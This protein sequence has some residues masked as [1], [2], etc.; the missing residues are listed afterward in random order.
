VHLNYLDDYIRRQN[1]VT[2]VMDEKKN[3]RS[4]RMVLVLGAAVAG[5]ALVGFGGL[6]AWQAYT[7]NAGNNF[8]VGTLSHTN[9]VGLGTVCASTISASAPGACSVIVSGAA[10]TS[11]FAG[12]SGTVT[13]TNTGSL[14]STFAMSMPAAPTGG[15]LCADLA[16][17]VTDGEG[18]PATV[19]SQTDLTQTIGPTA[20]DNSNGVATWAHGDHDTFTFAI[21]PY[22]NFANDD[23]VLGSTC[24]FTILFTQASA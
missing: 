8:A 22:N 19:Y 17:T 3:R 4:L 12:T 16:L 18:T 23:S 9:Q 20:L 15:A 10:L 21:A 13:I 2:R 14:S 1:E 24:G 6:A 5:T 7:Q 11:D